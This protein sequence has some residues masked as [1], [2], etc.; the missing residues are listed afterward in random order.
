IASTVEEITASLEDPEMVK[1]I[2]NL[3]STS[4]AFQDA[5]DRT[6]GILVQL[7]ESGIIDETKN[8]ASSVK[9]KRESIKS[10]QDLREMIVSFKDT[11]R[12]IRSIA[13]ELRGL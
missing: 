1:N 6:K 10:N 8:M 3:R 2:E 13:A 12:S 7:N 9:S 4:K 11:V 5:R